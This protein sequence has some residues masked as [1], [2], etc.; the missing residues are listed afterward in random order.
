MSSASLR[1]RAAR[2]AAWSG[3]DGVMRSVL[4]FVVTIVLARLV[5]PSEFG[6]VAIVLVFG[7]V[8]NV[9]V[10]GGLGAALIQRQDATSVEESTAFRFNLAASG[11]LAI[12]LG[13]MAPFIARFFQQPA[14]V[15]LI[16]MMA[17][18]LV[19]AALGAIHSTLLTKALRFRPLVVAGLSS[20][21]GAAAL[22]IWLALQ[23]FGAW[24]LAWQFL[25]QTT[26]NT[27]L[28][29]WLHPWRP[30]GGFDVPAFRRLFHF[31]GHFLAAR[32][33]DT[34]YT[35]IYSL[36]VG[37]AFGAADLGFYDRARSTQQ[38][39]SNLMATLLHRVALPAFSETAT[40]PRRLGDALE[41]SSRLVALASFPAMIG[42]AVTATPVVVLLFGSRWLPAAPL[43]EILA[44][45]GAL[46]P[47]QALNI[48]A[49]LAQGFSRLVLRMELAK[50]S[51]GILLLALAIPHGLEAIAWSQL[52]AACI[53]YWINTH[54]NG[55]LL[56][57]GTASQLR[58][59]WR[60]G[61]ASLAMVAS[62]A[63][64]AGIAPE[65]AGARVPLMV[66]C[67]AL[68]YFATCLLLREPAL[69]MARDMLAGIRP[70]AS[71]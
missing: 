49:L 17:A 38:L 70:R 19:I 63:L 59:L 40:D 50:K 41:R 69:I 12:L 65:A 15:G 64:L 18:N 42:L 71:T 23:G 28:L 44:L 54:F 46:W 26:I 67:G 25:A 36:V 6:L 30:V 34:V 68:V 37:K 58:A 57:F 29:W 8:A 45:A 3:F 11:A 66:G 52:V 31:G 24:A 56:A 60:I 4:G 13:L 53:A 32:L 48:N 43:L 2:A 39:P 9:L 20:S 61:V 10:D 33:I 7:T 5:A 55:R 62:L 27:V 22:S 21:A 51:I 14:L 47:L 1:D 16:W 35:R